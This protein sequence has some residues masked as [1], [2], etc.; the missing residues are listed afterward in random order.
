MLFAPTTAAQVPSGRC[1]S[2]LRTAPVSGYRS[3][4]V[5]GVV[6]VAP[7]LSRERSVSHGWSNLMVPSEG[8]KCWNR[9]SVWA[10]TG[11]LIGALLVLLSR[12][13]SSVSFTAVLSTGRAARTWTV[14]D[15]L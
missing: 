7:L 8:L 12:S 9:A 11:R 14:T 1:T 15:Q 2:S 13:F 4:G 3:V 5:I 6:M 10:A